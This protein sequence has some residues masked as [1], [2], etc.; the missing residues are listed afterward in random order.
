MA[1]LSPKERLQPSLLDRLTDDEPDQQ[2]ESRDRRV[3]SMSQLRQSVLRDVG[4]LL[5]TRSL[6]SVRN[7]GDYP[8]TTASV[9]NYG[10]RDL[11]GATVA[12]LDPG[13]LELRMREALRCFEPRIL[14]DTLRVRVL[15]EEGRMSHAAL[16]F[17][18]EGELWAQPLPLHLYIRSEVDRETGDVKLGAVHG[19]AATAVL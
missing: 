4:W 13:L 12:G 7:L 11:S 5:N 1:E 2:E 15:A 10:I 9:L 17:A 16:V 19:A 3:L 18:I 8:E 6:E 14:P